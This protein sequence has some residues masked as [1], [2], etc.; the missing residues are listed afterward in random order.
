MIENIKIKGLLSFGGEGIDLDLKPLNVLVGPNGSGKSNFLK[1]LAM[2]KQLPVGLPK[3]SAEMDGLRGWVWNGGPT[4]EISISVK[5]KNWMTGSVHHSLQLLADQF[6][7]EVLTESIKKPDPLHKKQFG[8]TYYEKTS[9]SSVILVSRSKIEVLEEISNSSSSSILSQLKFPG[10]GGKSIP[11]LQESYSQIQLYREWYFGISNPL[12]G[13]QSADLKSDILNENCDN[14]ASVLSNISITERVS[15]REN[16]SEIYDGAEELGFSV[17][18]GSVHMFVS[19]DGISVP[20][21]RLSDGTLRYLALLAILLNP[22]PPRLVAIE[23]PELG[24]HPDILPHIGKLIKEASK[25]MQIIVTTH[26]QILLD[27]FS[28]DPEDIVVCQKRG[29]ISEMKRLDREFLTD[30]L[31]EHSLGELWNMG[32]LG[33]NR[34]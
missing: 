3:P 21:T 11:G 28:E 32:H 5:L 19:E 16:L 23:E 29:N 14:L 13:G 26:S 33:G 25:R 6:E 22:K 30:F 24:L 9:S 8:K 34:W 27:A 7:W 10:A 2:I 17:S 1:V 4:D 12:R 15:I 18:G 20:A 31:S